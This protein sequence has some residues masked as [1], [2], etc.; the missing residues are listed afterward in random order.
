MLFFWLFKM[1]KTG[2]EKQYSV[3]TKVELKKLFP[4]KEVRATDSSKLAASHL[5]SFYNTSCRFVN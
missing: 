4:G 2:E 3:T 5:A 1:A